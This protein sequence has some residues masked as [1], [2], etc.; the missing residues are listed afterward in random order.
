MLNVVINLDSHSV[1]DRRESGERETP[2]RISE[3][4]ATQI[5][6]S[7]QTVAF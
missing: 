1:A 7:K 5:H 6:I 4:T 2:I 3:V